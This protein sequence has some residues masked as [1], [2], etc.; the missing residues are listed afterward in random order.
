[1]NVV[2]TTMCIVLADSGRRQRDLHRRHGY[3]PVSNL[4]DPVSHLHLRSG[5]G[6]ANER[7]ARRAFFGGKLAERD[8]R[9]APFVMVLRRAEWPFDDNGV[10][11]GC[12]NRVYCW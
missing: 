12:K 5:E 10:D 2:E 9:K 8:M 4:L 11:H 6:A 7:R 1:M 3:P